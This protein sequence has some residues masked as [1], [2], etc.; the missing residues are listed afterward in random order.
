MG[1]YT[2]TMNV[3]YVRTIACLGSGSRLARY[4]RSSVGLDSGSDMF[5]NLLLKIK[6]GL[7]FTV[8][9]PVQ[10]RCSVLTS[11]VT[12]DR[13]TQPETAERGVDFRFCN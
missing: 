9:V 13:K 6:E 2:N 7:I 11:T 3:V 4:W 1:V 5:F 10:Q 12:L 8:L